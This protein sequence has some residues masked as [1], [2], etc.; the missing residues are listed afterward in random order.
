M[1]ARAF[2][3]KTNSLQGDLNLEQHGLQ[4]TIIP[5]HHRGLGA[6]QKKIW[7]WT[8]IIVLWVTPVCTPAAK[9]NGNN[10]R[11]KVPCLRISRHG[12]AIKLTLAHSIFIVLPHA[13]KLRYQRPN[14]KKMVPT[15]QTTCVQKQLVS[16]TYGSWVHWADMFR[17][18]KKNKRC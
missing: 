4:P 10:K 6:A 11:H 3:R 13:G 17:R 1:E 16:S 9:D 2:S 7:V 8:M 12:L 18:N 15:S 5:L 14:F